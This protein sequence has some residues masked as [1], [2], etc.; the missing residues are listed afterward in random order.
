[1]GVRRVEEAGGGV[2]RRTDSWQEEGEGVK[3]TICAHIN[4]HVEPLFPVLATL[5]EVLHLK[6]LGFSTGLVILFEAAEGECLL[7]WLEERRFVREVMHHPVTCKADQYS[8][9]AFE[10]EDLVVVSM[11]LLNLGV[12]S[13]AKHTQAQPAFPPIPFI[14][15]IAAAN[16]PPKLP[17]KAAAEKKIAARI[18]NS[19]RLYQHDR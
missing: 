19:D 15:A 10:D 6:Y 7:F 18:P 11:A 16:K 13:S 9:Q 2:G 14:C 17:A 12:N 5:P 8:D 1:M 4:H 3:R